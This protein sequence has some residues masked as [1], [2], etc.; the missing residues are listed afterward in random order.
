MRVCIRCIYSVITEN[1]CS[2]KLCIMFIYCLMPTTSVKLSKAPWISSHHAD[3]IWYESA[4]EELQ[5]LQNITQR[6]NYNEQEKEK[7]FAFLMLGS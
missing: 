3:L 2:V 6:I 4:E 7:T 5:N 1:L